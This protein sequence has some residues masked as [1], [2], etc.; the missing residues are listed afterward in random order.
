MLQLQ[1]EIHRWFNVLVCTLQEKA[2]SEEIIAELNKAQAEL[3]QK[4]L[5]VGLSTVAS[6]FCRIDLLCSLLPV[7]GRRFECLRCQLHLRLSVRCLLS[8]Q[9]CSLA[10]HALWLRVG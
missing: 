3:T 7:R 5:S 4:V 9:C 8:V 10:S 1:R 6:C 2:G